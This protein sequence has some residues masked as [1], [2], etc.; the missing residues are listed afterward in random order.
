MGPVKQ[1][2]EDAGLKPS[3]VDEVVL[4]GGSTR[5]PKIQHLVKDFFG[6][7]PH[8]GVNP[9]EV[10]AIGAAIQ[11][12]VLKGEVKDV[13]LLDV[14]PL[15]LGIET[16]GGVMTTLIN[17]N[18]TIPTRKSEVF[19]TATD[20]QT[21]VEVH[22]LQGERQMARD[23]RTLGRFQLVGLPP[24][25]RGMPQ[26]EVA[27]DID[28]NGIVNVTAKDVATGKEQKITISN[29]SGLS[30]DD[31]DRMVKDAEGHA[32]EDKV[33]REVIDA[34]NQADSLAYSVEKTI[35]ENRDRLP[36]V[37]VERVERAIGVVRDAVKGDNLETIRAASDELQKAS[38]AIAEQLYK[39]QNQASGKNQSQA[40]GKNQAPNA[41][42]D[43]VVEG[44]VVDA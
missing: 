36:A 33:R 24:A 2:L 9:D 14:T 44:E 25:P 35:N 41:Q 17:R 30:K 12:G 42:H 15:S 22:V 27:F 40:Q 8:K 21:N 28:A 19:S 34:R 18:T 11:G 23:N 7:E 39:N 3:E 20:N 1:A 10:V 4:V 13:L 32:A 38:H 6:K 43:D 5:T 31:V 29:S 16:L 37:D 26:I